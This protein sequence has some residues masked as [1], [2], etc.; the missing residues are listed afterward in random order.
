MGLHAD[1]AP[2]NRSILSF[3]LYA[4]RCHAP[5]ELPGPAPYSRKKTKIFLGINAGFRR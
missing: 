4:P 3:R 5:V 2:E 1:H